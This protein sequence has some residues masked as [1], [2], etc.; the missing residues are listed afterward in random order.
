MSNFEKTGHASEEDEQLLEACERGDLKEVKKLVEEDGANIHI[1]RDF[2]IYH[3]IVNNHF[4]VV[5]YLLDKGSD[6]YTLDDHALR[7]AI[8]R[9]H[10]TMVTYLNM[11]RNPKT[12]KLAELLYFK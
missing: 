2:P 6:P 11:F 9:G 3:A 12:R 10:I 5:K 8:N 4:K 7:V 1:Y